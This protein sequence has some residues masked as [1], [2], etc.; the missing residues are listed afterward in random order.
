M[1]SETGAFSGV[2]TLGSTLKLPL[3]S[4][5]RYLFNL[6]LIDFCNHLRKIFLQKFLSLLFRFLSAADELCRISAY[7]LQEI[8]DR[9][10][11]VFQSAH[12]VIQ[13]ADKGS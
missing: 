8:I 9:G 3:S 11:G 12:G 1:R 7:I 13:I 10:Q 5:Q 2:T 4:H 6:F